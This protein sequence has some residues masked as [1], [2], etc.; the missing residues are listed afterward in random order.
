LSLSRF[1]KARDRSPQAL[2]LVTAVIAIGASL[3]KI[4]PTVTCVAWA[5]PFLLLGLFA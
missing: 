3:L 4:H 1:G 5:Y 2:A